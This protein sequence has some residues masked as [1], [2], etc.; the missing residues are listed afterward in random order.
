MGRHGPVPVRSRPADDFNSNA[1]KDDISFLGELR[2]G[3]S[4]DV[5]CNWRAVLAYRRWPSPAIANSVDQIPT[6]FTNAHYPGI[7]DSDSSIVVHGV[8]VGVE[9]R[10]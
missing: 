2:L 3:G 10:Y 4:Y 6:D 8:Q 1:N 7:I 5:T 9:C